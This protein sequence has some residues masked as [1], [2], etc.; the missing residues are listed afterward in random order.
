MAMPT[1]QPPGRLVSALV[2]TAV[3]PVMGSLVA[4]SIPVHIGLGLWHVVSSPWVRNKLE[5]LRPQNWKR[6]PKPWLDTS[7]PILVVGSGIGGL[8]VA[9]FLLKCGFTNIKVFEKYGDCGLDRGGGHGLI[10]GSW[11]YE[12]MGMPDVYDNTVTPATEWRFDSGRPF[13]WW[14]WSLSFRWLHENPCLPALNYRLGS[15]LRSDFLKYLAETLPEGVL[16]FHHEL[17]DIVQT[18]ET[19]QA[20]FANGTEYTGRLLIGCDGSKSPTRSLLRKQLIQN[21]PSTKEA[22]LSSSSDQQDPFYVDINVWWCVTKLSDIPLLERTPWDIGPSRLYFEGGAIM[23]LVAKDNLILVVDYRAPSLRRHHKNWTANA[24][25]TD[26]VAFMEHWNIPNRYRPVAKYASRVARFAIPKGF[27]EPA[28]FWHNAQNVVLL[29]DAV[30][31]TPHFFGQGA[32]AAIQDAYCLVRCL[33]E[34]RNFREA[35]S[36]Y[37][38][39]RKPPADD[40][41]SKSYLLGLTETA[42]G[43][44]RLVRDLIFFTVLKTGLFVWAAV[45]IN[46]VRV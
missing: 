38:S 30:H 27:E 39:I 29:G 32:N 14:S 45:D 2:S 42:G 18:D 46:T 11:C 6:L 9:H 26:L 13:G 24:T 37:V 22:P 17:V 1:T 35:V 15:F 5:R 44:A 33:H 40:I 25:G 31:P 34:R 20:V 23:H 19:V 8:T 16:Q 7:A 10:A 12:A 43:I 28:Q 3:L 41:V 21:H 36:E 4:V